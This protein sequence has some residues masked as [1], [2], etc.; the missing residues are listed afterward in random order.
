MYW[1]INIKEKVDRVIEN[2]AKI[3]KLSHIFAIFKYLQHQPLI[4]YTLSCYGKV[5]KCNTL[6]N[7]SIRK[8]KRC[9]I[10]NSIENFIK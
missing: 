4:I 2:N 1:F 9:K 8:K 5:V 10:F 6:E 3:N 7:F